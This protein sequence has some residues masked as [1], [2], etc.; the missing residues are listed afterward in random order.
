MIGRQPFAYF[1][2]NVDPVL[3][4]QSCDRSISIGTRR[5]S[6]FALF[7]LM[8]MSPSVLTSLC[9]C[10]CLCRKCSHF[11]MRVLM[12]MSQV[13]SLPYA[14]AYAYVASVL[15]SLCVCLCLC[16]CRKCSHFLMRVRMLMS[17]VFSLPYACAYAYV[18]RVLTS[19]C[20]CVCLCRKCSH[21]LMRVRMFMS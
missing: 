5:T 16:L 18:A 3:A 9:V 8:L 11:L 15:T 1:C 17:Q 19:L 13:F 6:M 4:N 12:L 20:V 2:A 10:L 7:E 21:F 14:C